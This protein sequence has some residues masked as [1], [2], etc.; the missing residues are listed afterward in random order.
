MSS[1]PIAPSSHRNNLN[2]TISLQ[3]LNRLQL[4]TDLV[5]RIMLIT[6]LTRSRYLHS[7]S[8]VLS[9][10]MAA[11]FESSFRNEPNGRT[12]GCNSRSPSTNAASIQH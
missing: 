4:Y 10:A 1:C 11:H 7:D 2:L 3:F 8:N 6:A 5:I 12:E 9:I